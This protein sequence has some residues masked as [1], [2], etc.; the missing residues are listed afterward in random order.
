M[1]ALPVPMFRLPSAAAFAAHA[2]GKASSETFQTNWNAMNTCLATHAIACSMYDACMGN[3]LNASVYCE[4][5]LRI[6]I[7][8]TALQFATGYLQAAHEDQ[9]LT[10]LPQPQSNNGSSL[11]LLMTAAISSSP[12]S[13]YLFLF[14]SL[15]FFPLSLSLHWVFWVWMDLLTSFS[16]SEKLAS[17]LQRWHASAVQLMSFWKKCRHWST[18]CLLRM[19]SPFNNQ[20]VGK[21]HHKDIYDKCPCGLLPSSPCPMDRYAWSSSD[22]LR[23]SG[24]RPVSTTNHN[25]SNARLNQDDIIVHSV[26]SI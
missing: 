11:P 6:S 26:H 23:E 13:F 3:C 5:Q 20:L 9:D 25:S 24:T 10:R 21:G 17:L 22:A 18:N 4:A 14:F 19:T 7:T 2:Q 12:F 1:L 8:H 16:Q 15:S